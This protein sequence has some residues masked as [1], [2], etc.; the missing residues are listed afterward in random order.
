MPAADT[1]ALQPSALRDADRLTALV[2]LNER[3]FFAHDLPAVVSILRAAARRLTGADGVTIWRP[4]P[5]R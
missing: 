4:V 2:D 3:L 1:D 5:L